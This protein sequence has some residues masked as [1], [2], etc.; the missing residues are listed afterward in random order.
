M[1]FSTVYFL[2]KAVRFCLY[3]QTRIAVKMEQNGCDG[4]HKQ[5]FDERTLVAILHVLPFVLN[6]MNCLNLLLTS[7]ISQHLQRRWKNSSF[8]KLTLN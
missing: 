2:N 7:E 8:I 3:K 6:K 4:P 5:L 1:L